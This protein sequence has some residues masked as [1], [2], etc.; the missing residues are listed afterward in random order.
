MNAAGTG[1]ER[2]MVT[3][4]N[5]RLAVRTADAWSDHVPDQ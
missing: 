2:Y 5:E 1:I 4:D 3:D